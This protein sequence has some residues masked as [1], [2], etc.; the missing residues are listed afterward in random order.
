MFELVVAFHVREFYFFPQPRTRLRGLIPVSSQKGTLT[1]LR[2]RAGLDR[3]PGRKLS[4]ETLAACASKVH[5]SRYPAALNIERKPSR[6]LK[7]LKE[8]PP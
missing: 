8:P 2:I 5:V 4:G 6:E 3:F 1:R 7:A